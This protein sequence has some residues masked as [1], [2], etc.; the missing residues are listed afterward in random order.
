ML[1]PYKLESWVWP[2]F[3]VQ[4]D[5][6]GEIGVCALYVSALRSDVELRTTGH[7]PPVFFGDEGREAVVH[8]LM[9]ANARETGNMWFLRFPPENGL[10]SE[11]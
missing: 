10:P 1:R 9:V 6:L 7:V 11:E 2:G 8:G 3:K 5:G 4:L